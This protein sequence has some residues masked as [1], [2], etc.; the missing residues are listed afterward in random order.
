MRRVGLAVLLA[1]RLGAGEY[2]VVD[3]DTDAMTARVRPE[4]EVKR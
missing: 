1:R 3:F 4:R 2:L